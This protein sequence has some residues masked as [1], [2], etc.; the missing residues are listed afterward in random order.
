MTSTLTPLPDRSK[1][2]HF[3]LVAEREKHARFGPLR[4]KYE[5]LFQWVWG[6]SIKDASELKGSEVYD[7]EPVLS[8]THKAPRSD[9]AFWRTTDCPET[10]AEETKEHPMT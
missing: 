2:A 8:T 9:S 5:V 3:L 10:M 4:H 7:V 1:F 6:I